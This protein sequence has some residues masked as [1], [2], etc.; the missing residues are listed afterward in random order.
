MIKVAV[1]QRFWERIKGIEKAFR[2]NEQLFKVTSFS[3]YPGHA[4]D[5]AKKGEPLIVV[6]GAVFD[7]RMEYRWVGSLCRQ[8]KRLNP[9]T[10]VV[11][12]SGVANKDLLTYGDIV[13]CHRDKDEDYVRLRDIVADLAQGMPYK[14]VE[15]TH[16]R[17][18]FRPTTEKDEKDYERFLDHL[19]H[20]K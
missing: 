19:S 2:E 1:V 9:Q 12:F 14:L 18:L 5:E 6:S 17:V 7:K 20:E 13:F 11:I 8:V 4:V 15:F 16:N 3:G 10:I